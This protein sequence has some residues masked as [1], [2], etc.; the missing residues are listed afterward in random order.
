[1]VL[2][3]GATAPLGALLRGK[4][5][6]KQRGDRGAKQHKGS[7]NAQPLIDYSGYTFSHYDLLF[8]TRYCIP[9]VRSGL[10]QHVICVK[11]IRVCALNCVCAWPRFAL[12]FGFVHRRGHHAFSKSSCVSLAHGQRWLFLLSRHR[13]AFLLL[14][15]RSL[16][17]IKIC[18]PGNL[19]RTINWWEPNALAT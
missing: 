6:K 17:Y 19:K 4:W 7:A 14:L 8:P 2:K 1:M 9:Y 5:V 3:L 13:K 11:G 12:Q 16:L 10:Y 18:A 15:I